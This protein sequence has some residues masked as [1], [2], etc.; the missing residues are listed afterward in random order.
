VLRQFLVSFACTSLP[1]L[2]RAFH[3][4]HLRDDVD[5]GG[6]SHRQAGNSHR[7]ADMFPSLSKN[8]DQKIRSPVHDE[9]LP[10]K[11]L[12]LLTRPWTATICLR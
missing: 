6:K 3:L 5:R 1:S 11:V 10:V 2:S 7:C 9:S 4:L 12:V 8:V